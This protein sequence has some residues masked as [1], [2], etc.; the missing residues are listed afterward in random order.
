MLCI[1]SIRNIK[2]NLG[3]S[4]KQKIS[5]CCRG[6]KFKTD[7]L[8]IN[9]NHLTQLVNV[10]NIETGEEILKPEQSATAVIQNIEIF[11]GHLKK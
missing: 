8:K 2:T 7:I 10:E 5:I 9:K 6:E 11:L 4:P 1:S 3:I